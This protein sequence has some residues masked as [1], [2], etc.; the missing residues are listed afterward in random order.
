MI[1]AG[2]PYT[3]K[4]GIPVIFDASRSY[5]PDGDFL[6]YEWNFGDGS[7]GRG[8]KQSHTYDN[9]G[10]YT[11]KL[12]ITDSEG[13]YDTKTM[14]VVITDGSKSLGE[15]EYSYALFGGEDFELVYT[16]SKE[17]ISK[18][19]GILVG[20]ITKEKKVRLSF[21]GQEKSVLD[22]GYDHFSNSI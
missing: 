5:D 4:V 10:S 12:T 19:D 13:N 1:N 17:N 15:D 14:E 21:R 2:G 9:E 22:R 3:G 11:V 8:A 7:I 20:E 16:V 6:T 18:I